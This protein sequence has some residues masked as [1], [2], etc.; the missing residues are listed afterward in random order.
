MGEGHKK[1][2]LAAEK[3]QEARAA[4][5]D[6]GGRTSNKLHYSLWDG[7]KELARRGKETQ[8]AAQELEQA[9]RA[10]AEAVEAATQAEARV[11]A[12]EAKQENCRLRNAHLAF[13]VAREATIGVHGYG[14]LEEKMLF[15]E[16]ALSEAGVQQVSAAFADIAWFIRR[17]E[18]QQYR[19]D[20][21]SVLRELESTESDET[22]EVGRGGVEGGST[23]G[24]G[25]GA[26]GE[27]VLPKAFDTGITVQEATRL[28]LA[29]ERSL[30]VAWRGKGAGSARRAAS[31][32]QHGRAEVMAVEKG[33]A[34]GRE[35]GRRREREAS[36]SRAS[37]RS[38][39]RKRSKERSRGHSEGEETELYGEE[40]MDWTREA[41]GT[42]RDRTSEAQGRGS[43]DL[44][45]MGDGEGYKKEAEA[46]RA[47][48]WGVQ[49]HC[50]AC[51]E[52]PMPAGAWRGECECGGPICQQCE[53]AS[54]CMRCNSKDS[55]RFRELL[56]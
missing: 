23:A 7:Q 8:A 4:L 35:G 31:E 2:A 5:K 29:N 52:G 39:G 22:V 27:V 21:D 42:K 18:P 20:D 13:E 32:G 16:A 50:L 43:V 48:G 49:E 44:A 26:T 34:V 38:R 55:K 3:L 47:G 45:I 33:S 19:E 17:F 53:G 30:P 54:A 46:R 11:S 40:E 41:R 51:G 25:G 6:A 56:Q 9:R 15:V 12:C 1:R 36:R 37:S 14:E 28:A 10:A 24:D